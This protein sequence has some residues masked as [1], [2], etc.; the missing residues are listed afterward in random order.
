MVR[1]DQVAEVCVA[2]MVLCGGPPAAHNILVLESHKPD[3]TVAT[4]TIAGRLASVGDKGSRCGGD[5]LSAA[6][7]TVITFRGCNVN[8]GYDR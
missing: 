7:G 5:C 4:D 3:G 8:A 2:D 6:D 1:S